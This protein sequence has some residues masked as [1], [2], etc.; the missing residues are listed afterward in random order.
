MLRQT[1]LVLGLVA[2]VLGSAL[3]VRRLP[4][5]GPARRFALSRGRI[6]GGHD[7]ARG[8]FPYQV[9]LQH[10]VLGLRYHNC[11]GSV[12][13]SNA[14]LSAG[15]C[16]VSIGSYI[17]VAGD[18]DLS[19]NEGSEQEVGVSDQTILGEFPYE[20]SPVLSSNAILT[21]GHCAVSI[22]SYIVS[23]TTVTLHLPFCPRWLD[24]VGGLDLQVQD[25]KHNGSKFNQVD[26]VT[27]RWQAVAGDHDLSS[28]EGSEQEVG[29]SDQT[30]H[31]DYPGGV[32]PK[33][34]AVFL[35]ESSLSLGTYVQ[36]ISLPSAGSIP[37]DTPTRDHARGS[38]AVLSGWGATE[39]AN[40]PDMLQTVDVTIID[41]ETCSQNI[42]DQDFGSNPLTEAM[43]Y[44]GPIYDGISV[45]GGDSGGPL[46]QNGELI[47]V[48]S[49][50]VDPCG[51]P[52]APSVFT[53][54]SA[55]LDFINQN[56]RRVISL[57]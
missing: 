31:P 45:C 3:P 4:H 49:W 27:C 54:V 33:D 50:G 35:L 39:T 23:M 43:V 29:V 57:A 32:A 2:C 14:I 17:A 16:A 30:V 6:Y 53:R 10:V 42:D 18:H 52:G 36:A 47:G 5:T 44:T 51:Y 20:V 24:Q 40:T 41:Y 7:A 28:N 55:H 25:V 21:A 37:A 9:S 46:A 11:G 26:H 15:H 13:S 38:I 22:G 48:V 56:A 1:V 34:I 12:L 19:S 8:E